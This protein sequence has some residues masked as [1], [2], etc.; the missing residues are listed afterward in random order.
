MMGRWCVGEMAS[1]KKQSDSQELIKSEQPAIS[2]NINSAVGKRIIRV[3]GEAW[4]RRYNISKIVFDG[5]FVDGIIDSL[6]CFGQA[7]QITSEDGSLDSVDA[8]ILGNVVGNIVLIRGIIAEDE[9]ALKVLRTVCGN[10]YKREYE[11]HLQLPEINPILAE[12]FNLIRDTLYGFDDANNTYEV[13]ELPL[14]IEQLAEVCI[15]EAVLHASN[16]ESGNLPRYI[17]KMVKEKEEI[18]KTLIDSLRKEAL[19]TDRM[20]NLLNAPMY[21]D[22]IKRSFLTLKPNQML[23]LA[24]RYFD[25]QQ[26]ADQDVLETMDDIGERQRSWGNRT[27]EVKIGNIDKNVHDILR[28]ILPSRLASEFARALHDLLLNDDEVL[29]KHEILSQYIDE[30]SPERRVNQELLLLHCQAGVGIKKGN[31]MSDEM[32]KI[33]RL[34]KNRSLDA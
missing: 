29:T 22:C 16:Q 24:L 18:L 31:L 11:V 7:L 27:V 6:E 17:E 4:G 14:S 33:C 32:V 28:R 25:N 5:T 12:A 10:I 21:C 13:S 34:L 19:K 2:V 1:R 20:W 9:A 30:T 23:L 26:I 3:L 15:G 8:T